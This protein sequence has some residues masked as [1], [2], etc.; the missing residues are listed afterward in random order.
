MLNI[1]YLLETLDVTVMCSTINNC[2]EFT[3]H[4]KNENLFTASL[5]KKYPDAITDELTPIPDADTLLMFQH[6][7]TH[8]VST[9]TAI[10]NLRPLNPVQY[11]MYKTYTRAFEN[12]TPTLPTTSFEH[13]E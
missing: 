5:N 6:T 4:L 10:Q 8:F 12:R 11:A 9:L 7:F 2:N 1:E 13:N 3:E